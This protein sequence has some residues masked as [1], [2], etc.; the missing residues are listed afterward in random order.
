[1]GPK[2]SAQAAPGFTRQAVDIRLGCGFLNHRGRAGRWKL[3]T[4]RLA[5]GATE[6]M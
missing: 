3:T 2:K 6:A 1:M 5:G 4:I